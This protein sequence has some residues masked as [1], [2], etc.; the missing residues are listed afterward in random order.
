MRLHSGLRPRGCSKAPKT[1]VLAVNVRLSLT[2][3]G[4]ALLGGDAK[5]IPD[6]ASPPA[7]I[8]GQRRK[9]KFTRRTGW[10]GLPTVDLSHGVPTPEAPTIV[11]GLAEN[12]PTQS[13]A[14]ALRSAG[15]QCMI[16]SARARTTAG[17][18]PC[19][20]RRY[21]AEVRALASAPGELCFPLIM[22]LHG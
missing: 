22:D 14:T 7:F 10:R 4:F 21:G 11:S 20:P 5:Y 17:R 9:T 13:C 12:T 1:Q 6:P 16:G 8:T 19:V 2:S 18:H 3:Q 15:N